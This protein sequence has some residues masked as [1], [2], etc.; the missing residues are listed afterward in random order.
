[1]KYKITYWTA[2]D[3]KVERVIEVDTNESLQD[4]ID[5]LADDPQEPLAQVYTIEFL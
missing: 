4:E 5:K 3:S 1:M 2:G